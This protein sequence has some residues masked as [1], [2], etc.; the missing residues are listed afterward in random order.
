MYLNTTHIAA[1]FRCLLIFISLTLIS[2]FSFAQF[3]MAAHLV[4]TG[5]YE[6]AKNY[7]ETVLSKDSLNFNANQELGLLLVQYFDDRH[8]ALAYLNR[9]IRTVKKKEM[10]PELYLG[11]A[12]ALHY[13][14]QYEHAIPYYQKTISA[15][16]GA[17]AASKI[18]RQA[19]T[20]IENC[21]Y[22]MA[23]GAKNNRLVKV[24]PISAAVNT[25]YPEFRPIADPDNLTL[26][27]SS[28]RDIELY[29]KKEEPEPRTPGTFFAANINEGKPV[30]GKLFYR[31]AS[32]LKFTEGM[33]DLDLMMSASGNGQ[34]MLIYRNNQLYLTDFA[35]GK[36]SVARHL[37]ATINSAPFFEG[38]AC[39]NNEGNVIIY[40]TRKPGGFGGYDL[41]RSVLTSSGDWSEGENL[42]EDIN[43]AGDEDFPSLSYDEKL[44]FYASN[45]LES[46]GGFDLFKCRINNKGTFKPVNMGLPYNS[47]ADDIAIVY[48]KTGNDGYLSSSR[49]GTLGDYDIFRFISFEMPDEQNCTS[50]SNPHQGDADYLDFTF[51]D[52][53]FVNTPELF[54]A[55]ISK[56]SGRNIINFFW[57]IN[58]T[59]VVNDTPRFERSF[60]REAIYKIKL[61][62][63]TYADAEGTR[64]DFCIDKGLHVFNP[65]AVDVFFEPLV[66]ANED[67]LA[68]KGT[69]DVGT[70]KIDSTKKEIL[71]I[72][73]ESVFFNTNKFDLR[74]DAQDAIKRNISK[75]K[76]D[77][78]IIVKLSAFTDPRASKEYNLTLSQKRANSVITALEKSGIKRKRIIAVLALGEEETS[79]KNCNGD[80]ACLEKTYQF[81]RRVEFKIVGAEYIPPK[82][83]PKKGGKKKAGAKPPAKKA[84]RK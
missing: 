33:Q 58:D 48:G 29:N 49:K 80:A 57:K 66:K 12:Q 39:V 81:N 31:P 25:P 73:L 2:A 68:L 40:S 20:G 15:L 7:Y 82:P 47:P 77:P 72:K 65:K 71:N 36:W 30:S 43:S 14:S 4:S 56:I 5:D 23:N 18:K 44:L 63:A 10:L 69:V 83:S 26:F 6:G 8:K 78:A 9:A 60:N 59:T 13:D 76:V 74:K 84:A 42:G 46:F 54:D 34:H 67:K 11:F 52:S 28:R 27:Y 32:Q 19:E 3:P 17:P 21:K 1:K 37:T 61:I 75:M 51:K 62:A 16:N 24:N 35:D 22:G 50:I 38:N 79:I 55:G 45:G 53:I 70:L 41:Y 64:K